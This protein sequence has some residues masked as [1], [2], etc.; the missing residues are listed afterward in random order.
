MGAGVWRRL[1][2]EALHALY[3]SPTSLWV[4]KSRIRWA[5]HVTRNGGGVRRVQGFGGEM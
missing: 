1:H 5:G 3:S 2:N 4:I